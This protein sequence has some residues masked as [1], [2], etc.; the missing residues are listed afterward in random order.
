MPL[1]PTTLIRWQ[2]VLFIGRVSYLVD[3]PE[4]VFFT[5]FFQR[6][7]RGPLKIKSKT[8]DL[9][10]KA[11]LDDFLSLGAMEVEGVNNLD[12]ELDVG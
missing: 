6:W 5:V 2:T 11:S 4:P 8:A 7:G 10:Q 12:F 1:L 3:V 9:T